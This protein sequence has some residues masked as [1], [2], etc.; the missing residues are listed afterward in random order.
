MA[1]ALLHHMYAAATVLA[2]RYA[3]EGLISP[4]EAAR[5]IAQAGPLVTTT[6]K[7]L[8]QKGMS[9][10]QIA[11]QFRAKLDTASS[12]RRFAAEL[13]LAMHD[14]LQADEA[15]YVEAWRAERPADTRA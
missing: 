12:G 15:A 11:A 4:D 8:R 10:E 2:G 13:F 9:H 1:A 3:D 5:T 6:V 14:G 7:S